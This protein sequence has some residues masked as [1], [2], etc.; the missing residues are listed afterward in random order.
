MQLLNKKTIIYNIIETCKKNIKM[1]KNTQNY[2]NV[3]KMKM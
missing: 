3:T 2:S 1:T